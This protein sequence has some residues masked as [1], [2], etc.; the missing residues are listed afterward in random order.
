MKMFVLAAAGL[1]AIATSASADLV[2]YWNFNAST[3]NTTSG[4]LGTLDSTAPSLGSGTL[5]IGGGS[6]T[7]TYNTNNAGTANG[8]VGTFAGTTLNA[9]N[10]DPVGGAL[11]LQGAVGGGSGSPV[12]SNG[13]YFQFNISMAGLKDLIVSFATRGTGTGFRNGQLSYSTDG[14]TFTNYGASWD[15]GG[16]S[17]FFLVTRDLSTETSLN[18]ASNVAIRLTLT[19]AT[20][21]AGNNRIDNIQFNATVIPAP[22]SIALVGLAGLV[23]GRRRR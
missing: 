3:P 15:G 17:T 12:T 6:P 19:G 4:Q 2:A 22:A 20:G 13:G 14:V 8:V 23:A 21:G 1:A 10:A 5:S 18:N 16:S 7:I 11:S 9:L